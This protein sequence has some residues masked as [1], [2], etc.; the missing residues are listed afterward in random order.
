MPIIGPT[1]GNGDDEGA[2]G[3]PIRRGIRDFDGAR[4][5]TAS[6][7]RLVHHRGGNTVFGLEVFGDHA[8][9]HVF[10]IAGAATE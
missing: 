6:T 9:Q 10:E 7:A 8:G 3:V 4:E 2:D 1:T 5:G